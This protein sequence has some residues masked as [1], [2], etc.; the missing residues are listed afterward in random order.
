M[1]IPILKPL[2]LMMYAGR[3]ASSRLHVSFSLLDEKTTKKNSA[4]RSIVLAPARCTCNLCTLQQHWK[5]ASG[6]HCSDKVQKWTGSLGR[7]LMCTRTRTLTTET[8]SRVMIVTM[9]SDDSNCNAAKYVAQ[10]A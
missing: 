4:V 7:A 2:M 6:T 3:R 5:I 10:L 1:D 9:H 8:E